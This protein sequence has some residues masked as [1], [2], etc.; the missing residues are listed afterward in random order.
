MVPFNGAMYVGSGIQGGGID[1]VNKIG[2][3]AAE[4]IRI[5]PDDSWDLIVGDRRAGRNDREPLS[6]LGSGFGDVFNGYVWSLCVHDGWLY[7]GTDN[8]SVMLRWS[9]LRDSPPKVV[10][11]FGHIDPEVIVANGAGADLWRS[12]DGENW[13]PVTRRGFGNL[14]NA[15]IRNLVSTPHGLF[16]GTSN[17]FGPRVAVRH[18]TEWVYEDNPHGGLEVWQGNGGAAV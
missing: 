18:G 11:F 4:L 12:R 1:R 14:Y 9:S 8:W 10:R 17:L 15:G 13:M 16:A 7:A 5:N 3:A 6:G 2:P